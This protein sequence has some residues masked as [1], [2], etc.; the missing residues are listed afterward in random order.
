MFERWVQP[1]L[2]GYLGPYIKD[3]QR[4]QLKIGLWNGRVGRL[5]IK[6]PWKKLGLSPIII[7]LEDVFIQA[8][9]RDEHEWNPDLVERRDIAGKKAKLTAA[10]L[11]KFSRRV[12]EN[13]TGQ[14]FVSYIT[15][16]LLD[17][18]Q[19][20]IRNFRVTYT[21]QQIG[22]DIRQKSR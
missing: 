2:L 22:S 14:A 12:C 1:L 4:E 7:V 13:Q 10:E 19:V 20:S 6:I 21:D 3:F 18:V 15:A 17:N 5:S 8:G 16:K 11:A 9:Q